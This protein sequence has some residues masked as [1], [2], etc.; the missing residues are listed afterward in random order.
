MKYQKLKKK[1]RIDNKIAYRV[2][3][4]DTFRLIVVFDGLIV[5]I[6]NFELVQVITHAA[7]MLEIPC[8]S[9]H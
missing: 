4:T 7:I 6:I 9:F 3:I 2:S 5:H 1:K 8:V